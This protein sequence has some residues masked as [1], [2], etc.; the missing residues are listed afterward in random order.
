VMYAIHKSHYPALIYNLETPNLNVLT[1]NIREPFE[2][3]V[4][5]RQ[6]AAVMQGRCSTTLK[7]VLLKQP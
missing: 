6:N 5:W 3:F 7:R 2:K 1:I 4:D